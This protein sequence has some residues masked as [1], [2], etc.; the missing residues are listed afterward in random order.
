MA[1]LVST[2]PTATLAATG[3]HNTAAFISTPGSRSL[4]TNKTPLQPSAFLSQSQRSPIATN[5]NGMRAP[6]ASLRSPLSSLKAAIQHASN[7]HKDSP[8]NGDCTFTTDSKTLFGKAG[9]FKSDAA[10][11]EHLN[12]YIEQCDDVMETVK[13]K[14]SAGEITPKQAAN[15]QS[16]LVQIGKE[17][18]N[19]PIIAQNAYLERFRQGVTPAQ[20][21]HELQQFS[22]FAFQF[23]VSLA[24]MIANADSQE[25]WATYTT[26]LAN[27]MGAP[28]AQGFDGELKGTFSLKHNHHMW[29]LDNAKDLGLSFKDIGALD[30]AHSGTKDFVGAIDR[31][32]TS[33]DRN[34]RGGAAFAIENWAA[35]KFWPL[36]LEGVNT[37][38]KSLPAED[39]VGASYI[40]YHDAEERH[41]SKETID[42]LLEAFTTEGFE[43]NTFLD[44]AVK[45][46]NEGVQAYYESQL[47][48]IPEKNDSWPKSIFDTK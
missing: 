33:A 31:Y 22:V 23:N 3:Q 25:E 4:L 48:T 8:A 11:P 34:V 26:I 30:V 13:T 14:V 5:T 20:A 46:L 28:F 10:N 21:R 1:S 38:N 39:R 6:V 15:F 7:Q 45:M 16:F 24:K 40:K 44:S 43:A 41:H 9:V 19:H 27:E 47:A 29:L 35:A 2:S 36:W 17:V 32:Y 37:M 42:E 18:M 12:L